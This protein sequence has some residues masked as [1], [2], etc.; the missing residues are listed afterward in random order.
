ML[1][2]FRPMHPRLGRIDPAELGDPSQFR[3]LAERPKI[4]DATCVVI[5]HELREGWIESYWLDPA[6]GYLPL[7]QHVIVN[8]QDFLRV[9]LSYRPDGN[10]WIPAGW[11]ETL[12]G[13]GGDVLVGSTSTVTSFTVNQPIPAS[14][15]SLRFPRRACGEHARGP[16]L[17]G[18]RCSG[19]GGES[20]RGETENQT[21]AA[22][23]NLRPICR[24][25]RRRSSGPEGRTRNEESAC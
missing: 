18:R 4:G 15:S 17:G 9:D 25:G 11:T 19:C 2:V 8:G 24:R 10:G 1:F 6:R 12:I 5:Q 23:T 22:E 7:R 16:R 14:N 20:Q 3:V 21:A 13:S